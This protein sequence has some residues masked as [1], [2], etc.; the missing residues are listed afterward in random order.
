MPR[1]N[2]AAAATGAGQRTQRT[3]LAHGFSVSASS[4]TDITST[5]GAGPPPPRSDGSDNS[6]TGSVVAGRDTR[7]DGSSSELRGGARAFSE[8]R[9]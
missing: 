9:V 7:D 3:L 5:P 2:V 1:G 8:Y 6:G 4:T